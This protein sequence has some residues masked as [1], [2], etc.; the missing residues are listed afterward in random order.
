MQA[1]PMTETDV[2]HWLEM[3]RTL[4]PHTEAERHE[5]EVA[6]ILANRSQKAAFVCCDESDVPI[7]FVE[8]FLRQHVDGCSTT[9]VGYIEGVFV[10][11][12]CRRQGIATKLVEAAERW[13][14]VRRCRQMASGADLDDA[15][16]QQLHDRF[17]FEEAERVVIFRKSLPDLESDGKQP[18]EQA[19]ALS[20]VSESAPLVSVTRE[21]GRPLWA[22]LHVVVAML[23][24]VSLYYTN[25]SSP[26]MLYGVMLPLVDVLCVLYALIVLAVWRYRVTTDERHRREALFSPDS[27]DKDG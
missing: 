9:P 27:D 13:A 16:G 19:P 5:D 11:S 15:L 2:D 23:G 22:A 24:V 21:E 20:S 1:R 6:S 10:R 3:R 12:D 25:I 26:D 14:R 17:G 8:V 4:W 18:S 7:G